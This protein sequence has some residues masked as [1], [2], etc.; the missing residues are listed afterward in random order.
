MARRKKN[1][2]QSHKKKNKLYTSDEEHCVNFVGIFCDIFAQPL[3]ER[4]IQFRA[5]PTQVTSER[6]LKN[7]IIKMSYIQANLSSDLSFKKQPH[8]FCAK[9]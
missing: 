8:G 9:R 4:P 7:I 6:E 5:A 3:Q 2:Y 1:I